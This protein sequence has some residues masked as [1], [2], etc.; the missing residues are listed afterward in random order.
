MG[1]LVGERLRASGRAGPDRRNLLWLHLYPWQKFPCLRHHHVCPRDCGWSARIGPIDGRQKP[2]QS[3]L[4]YWSGIT[5]LPDR[6]LSTLTFHPPPLALFED[7]RTGIRGIP[8]PDS[9]PAVPFHS[10]RTL[11]IIAEVGGHRAAYTRFLGHCWHHINRSAC[12][13]S[14]PEGTS[15]LIKSMD[16]LQKASEISARR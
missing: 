8:S 7:G 6:S 14:G 1:I 3:G 4:R 2:G 5:S 13:N 12:N 10:V 15:A 16:R 11:D 9:R